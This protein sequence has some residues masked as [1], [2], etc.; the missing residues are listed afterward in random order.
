M[1][2]YAVTNRFHGDR[3]VFSDSEVPQ[4]RE[5]Y[6]SK[7]TAYCRATADSTADGGMK[8][9]LKNF[10]YETALL[11]TVKLTVRAAW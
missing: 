4:Q 5:D 7:S 2:D 10:S 6:L 8:R 3:N 1:H 9:R 11:L